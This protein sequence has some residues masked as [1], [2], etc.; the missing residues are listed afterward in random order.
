MDR[1]QSIDWQAVVHEVAKSQKRLS[2]FYYL[3]FF[4]TIFFRE[5]KSGAFN[6]I[7]VDFFF[8]VTF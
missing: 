8:N 2:D 1:E 4:S 6:H 3:F 5:A 7:F